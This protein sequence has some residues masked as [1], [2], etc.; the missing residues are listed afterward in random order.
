M[1]CHRYPYL[2]VVLILLLL[3]KK[4]SSLFLL[5]TQLVTTDFKNNIYFKYELLV[6]LEVSLR[7][8]LNV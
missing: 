1:A 2:P 4:K 3:M 7:T 5:L 6:V 8:L